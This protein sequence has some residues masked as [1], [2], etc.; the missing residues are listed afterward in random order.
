VLEISVIILNCIRQHRRAK[1]SEPRIERS[2]VCRAERHQHTVT[3]LRPE[4][5]HE[6]KTRHRKQ[7]NEKAKF[8]HIGVTTNHHPYI[9]QRRLNGQEVYCAP[10]QSLG[11]PAWDNFSVKG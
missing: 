3:G 8:A 7:H 5:W 9:Q 1:T 6:R 10:Q 4:I 2:G 11:C